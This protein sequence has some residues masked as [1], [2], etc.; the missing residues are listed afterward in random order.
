MKIK[1][2]LVIMMSL[3]CLVSCDQKP[4]KEQNITEIHYTGYSALPDYETQLQEMVNIFE[5]DNPGVKVKVELAPYDSYFT[6]L[7]TLLAAGKAPDVY[8]M[9]YETFVSYSKKGVLKD[10]SDYVKNDKDFDVSSINMKSFDVFKYQGKQYGMTES[11]SNV[12][13]FY[14]KDLFDKFGVAYPDKNMR[15]EDE[16]TLAKQL[17][18]MTKPV[19]GTY[20]PITMTEFYK[21]SA[22]NKGTI[23]NQDG[24]LTINTPENIAALQHMVDMVVK[25]KVSPSL[26]EMSGQKSEDLFMNGQL[27]MV[28]TGI[29]MFE[30]F[31]N[32]PFKWDI[33]IEAG[34]KQKATHF[35][36]EGN[37]VSV[38]S[39]HP[40]LAYKFAKF[41]SIDPRAASIRI[42]GMWN[43][44]ISNDT[45]I[46]DKYNKSIPLENN[47]AIFE[48]LNYLVL[49]PA[50]DNWSKLSDAANQEFQKVVLGQE[51]AKDALDNLQRRFQ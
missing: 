27:A 34:E 43:L 22:Q 29:W 10:L 16:I 30:Q 14:N 38:S 49:P 46:I 20:S 8:E 13:T 48:S 42:A 12:V 1:N 4:S 47:N 31:K 36:A 45:Q 26:A 3:I 24:L 21:V 23:Y 50:S 19:Y 40:E 11:F 44:P 35:F 37:V 39:Q 5:K 51:S 15:W 18:D 33:Q 32:A 28:H 7:Q 41:M 25:Y 9:N 6:K 17:T 2:L